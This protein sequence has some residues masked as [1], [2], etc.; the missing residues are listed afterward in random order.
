MLRSYF[1]LHQRAAEICVV[2]R[3]S[4]IFTPGHRAFR[5]LLDLHRRL[6]GRKGVE[7]ATVRPPGC[8][9]GQVAEAVVR[10]AAGR[11]GWHGQ[12]AFSYRP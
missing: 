1:D 5:A 11:G 6:Q 8:G 12:D 7:G 2:R 10:L 3:W 9:R 4:V